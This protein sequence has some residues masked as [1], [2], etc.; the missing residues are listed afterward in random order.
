MFWFLFL[1]YLVDKEILKDPIVKEILFG[2]ETNALESYKLLVEN[3]SPMKE[4][5]LVKARIASILGI[6]P[7][8]VKKLFPKIVPAKNPSFSPQGDRIIFG[9]VDPDRKKRKIGIFNLKDS[10]L[11]FISEKE[12]EFIHGIF[13]DDSLILCVIVDTFEDI[14]ILNLKDASFKRLTLSIDMEEF[15][16]YSSILQKVFFQ[17]YSPD[18][19]NYEIACMD[20][21]NKKIELL[22]DNIYWDGEP[23]ISKNGRKLLFHSNPFFNFNFHIYE[24]DLIKK[25]TKS[26]TQ[27]M[28]NDLQPSY[29]KDEGIVFSSDREGGREIFLSLFMGEDT[30]TIR[31]TFLDGLNEDPAV[32]PDGRYVVF[33]NKNPVP[34]LYLIDFYSPIST[35]KLVNY[36][37]CRF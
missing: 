3:Q 2:E 22:T 17:F 33:V 8:E 18:R 28:W 21:K 27:G 16:S 11:R 37:P 29:Y 10:S 34:T 23:C 36:L 1:C 35:K 20:L 9:S 7:F 5:I 13:L 26:L 6:E 12:R 32:S 4:N 19:G 31:L 15:P 14:G 24:M 30:L 25:E